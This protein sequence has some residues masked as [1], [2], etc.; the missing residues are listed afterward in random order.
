MAS[1]WRFI[2]VA[3]GD[4][5]Y[6]Y[7]LGGNFNSQYQLSV[8]S[9]GISLNDDTTINGILEA[10][11]SVALGNQR[12]F[13]Q[14]T[15]SDIETAATDLLVLEFKQ[16]Q[17][18]I[19]YSNGARVKI[20]CFLAGTNAGTPSLNNYRGDF[21]IDPT[22]PSS[23]IFVIDEHTQN[24]QGTAATILSGV[25]GSDETVTL[26]L[27]CSPDMTSDQ[28]ALIFYEILSDNIESIGDPEGS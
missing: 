11:G 19:P 23:S 13:G 15:V 12:I 17:S 28:T 6:F 8:D 2:A 16:V 24:R 14:K 10:S 7:I 5:N 1:K 9:D 18:A 22:L 25:S 3:K 4:W 21:Y 20:D 27:S 26:Q